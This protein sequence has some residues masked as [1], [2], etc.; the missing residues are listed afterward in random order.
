[1]VERVFCC[2]KMDAVMYGFCM[3]RLGGRCYGSRSVRLCCRISVAMYRVL[4]VRA[5][6]EDCM[7]L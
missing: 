4:V 7:V 5:S 2:S 1:M 3:V 6:V